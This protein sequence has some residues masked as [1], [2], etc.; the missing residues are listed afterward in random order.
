MLMAAINNQSS[1]NNNVFPPVNDSNSFTRNQHQSSLTVTQIA[2]PLAHISVENLEK[3]N[4]TEIARWCTQWEAWEANGLHFDRNSL[5]PRVKSLISTWWRTSPPNDI[6]STQ[7]DIWLDH[8]VV[9]TDKLT[10]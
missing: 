8:T 7:S 2:P 4:V 3:G 6:Y 9:P 1:S 5:H 10:K